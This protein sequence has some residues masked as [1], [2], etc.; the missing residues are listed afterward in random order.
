[1]IQRTLLLLALACTS[2][3]TLSPRHG[4]LIKSR[5]TT[6]AGY[7]GAPNDRLS[8]QLFNGITIAWEEVSSTTSS[9]T[10]VH[11]DSCNR[12]WYAWQ[13]SVKLPANVPGSAYWIHHPVFTKDLIRTRVVASIGGTLH[14]FDGSSDACI[15]RYQCADDILTN[16]GTSHSET[17]LACDKDGCR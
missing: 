1:M 8:I 5:T 6:F 15:A 11:T 4:Q 13:K 10:P 7:H 17:M 3:C 16:C 12:N 14:T 9:A 2:A